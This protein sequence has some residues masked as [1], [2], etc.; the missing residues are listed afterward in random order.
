MEYV[1]LS[2]SQNEQ[3]QE[4][5]W[6]TPITHGACLSPLSSGFVHTHTLTRPLTAR[7]STYTGTCATA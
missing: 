7:Y 4:Q 2:F 1:A 5:S 3:E 6:V